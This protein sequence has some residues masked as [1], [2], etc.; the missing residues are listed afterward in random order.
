MLWLLKNLSMKILLYIGKAAVISAE[1]N[2][3]FLR[4]NRFLGKKVEIS[5]LTVHT[6]PTP[7]PQDVNKKQFQENDLFSGH[8]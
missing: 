6:L 8:A 7:P 5:I 3:G 2:V 4:K 1:N